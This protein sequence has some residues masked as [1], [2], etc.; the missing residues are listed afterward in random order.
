MRISQLYNQFLDPIIVKFAKR[1]HDHHHYT[2]GQT[3]F[4]IILCAIYKFNI[5]EHKYTTMI[6][7]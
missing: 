7:N 4:Y 1:V 5:V 6:D 3:N 2:T